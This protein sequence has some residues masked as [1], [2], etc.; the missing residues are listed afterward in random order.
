M[1]NTESKPQPSVGLIGFS[2]NLEPDRTHYDGLIVLLED[3]PYFEDFQL[4]KNRVMHYGAPVVVALFK[5]EGHYKSP[6]S[7]IVYRNWNEKTLPIDFIVRTQIAIK[8]R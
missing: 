1:G 3:E 5:G 8:V 2:N 4:L 7:W 6:T